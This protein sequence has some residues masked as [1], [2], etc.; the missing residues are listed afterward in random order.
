M[1]KRKLT[2]V[3]TRIKGL[4]HLEA[5]LDGALRNCNRELRLNQEIEHEDCCPLLTKLE[6]MNGAKGNQY[7]ST[8]RKSGKK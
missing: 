1:L 7:V 2:D 6:G 8:G 3:R 5:E 4:S